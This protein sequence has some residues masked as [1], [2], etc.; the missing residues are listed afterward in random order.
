MVLRLQQTKAVVWLFVLKAQ[1]VW[2]MAQSGKSGV[3]NFVPTC[4]LQAVIRVE[5]TDLKQ[6]PRY[7][8]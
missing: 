5:G 4:V 3:Y 1:D 6:W 2:V 7:T 8:F